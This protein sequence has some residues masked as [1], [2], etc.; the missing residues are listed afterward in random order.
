MKAEG[1]VM[2]EM[3]NGNRPIGILVCPEYGQSALVRQVAVDFRQQP[4]WLLRRNGRI[5]EPRLGGETGFAAIYPLPEVIALRLSG[6][7]VPA[8]SAPDLFSNLPSPQIDSVTPN[9]AR[10]DM[11]TFMAPHDRG[12]ERFRPGTL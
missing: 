1:R 7:R 5:G 10:K 3:S 12:N 6:F 2:V 9:L 4:S 8:S 11:S